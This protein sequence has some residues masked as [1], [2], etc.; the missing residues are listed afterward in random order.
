LQNIGADGFIFKEYPD[1]AQDSDSS[2]SIKKLYETIRE[3]LQYSFLKE[4]FELCREIESHLSTQYNNAI[5]DYSSFIKSLRSQ[6]NVIKS[7]MPLIKMEKPV[8]IDIA[9]LACYNFL[10]LFKDYYL[11]ETKDYR[12]ELGIEQVDLNRYIIVNR[13]IDTEEFV[14]KNHNDSPS[15][16]HIQAGL[17]VDYFKSLTASYTDLIQIKEIA[18]WRND[19]IH[20]DKTSFTTNE[21]KII[22]RFMLKQ[23]RSL[24]E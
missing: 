17:S 15:W 6:L 14:R 2:V 1:H 16:F 10:E 22:I 13:K 24:K 5:D 20:S 11:R 12:Y 7:A 9:F 8:T 3:Q 4:L 23:C 21:L 18:N 19:Y